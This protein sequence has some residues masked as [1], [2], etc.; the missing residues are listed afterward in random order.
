MT[1]ETKRKVK[2]H[3]ESNYG[4]EMIAI[5]GSKYIK[6]EIFHAVKNQAGDKRIMNY[7]I[8]K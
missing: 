3:L 1:V 2:A 5:H 6:K 4:Q 7:G 8:N